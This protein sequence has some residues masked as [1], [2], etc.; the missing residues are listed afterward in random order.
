MQSGRGEECAR[1]ALGVVAW[2]T[3][4]DEGD[5]YRAAHEGVRASRLEFGRQ[6]D[7]L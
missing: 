3:H 1:R 6:M 4:P 5:H 2:A 7:R